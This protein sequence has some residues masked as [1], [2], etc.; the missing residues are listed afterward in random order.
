MN[1][2]FYWE[3]CIAACIAG[4]LV[5]L[6]INRLDAHTPH[7]ERFGAVMIAAGCF[8]K[9]M[10]WVWGDYTI[11]LAAAL[12]FNGAAFFSIALLR[13]RIIEIGRTTGAYFRRRA[14]DREPA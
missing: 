12:M 7:I 9:A 6:H 8:A 14:T 10:Q 1:H 13:R 2:F 4:L 3:T 11:T 5:C